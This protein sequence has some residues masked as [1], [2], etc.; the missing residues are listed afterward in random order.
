MNII[1]VFKKFPEQKD[2]ILHLENIRWKDGVV[3]PYCK[4]DN[5]YKLEHDERLRHHC[6][7]CKKSFSVTVNTIFHNTRLPMQKWFLAISLLTDAKKSISSRQIAR[8]LELP[9]KTAYSVSQ[10]IRKALCGSSS[11]LLKGVVEI[12]ETYVGGKPR[13]KSPENKRGRGTKKT[14]V[15]GAVERNGNVIAKSYS[16]FNQKE[17]RNLIIENVD[18]GNSEIH[19]DEYCAYN[20]VKNIA[21]HKRVNHGKREY[22]NGMIHTNTIEGFWASVKRAFYGQHHHYS[23]KY[24]DLYIGEAC[25]KYNSRK[26]KSEDVFLSILNNMLYV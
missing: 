5:N 8:H 26:L 18:L 9:V 13:N 25:F 16:K 4:S 2:C 12:D 1:S 7:N 15:V 23:K 24:T 22:V 21:K 11:P 3:C 20:K 14:M 19:T 17:V 6:N 10:R